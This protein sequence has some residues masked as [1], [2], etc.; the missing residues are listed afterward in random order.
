[1]ENLHKIGGSNQRLFAAR[2][3]LWYGKVDETILLFSDCNLKQAEN[4][5]RIQVE[6]R[7]M[8]EGIVNSREWAEIAARKK[9]IAERA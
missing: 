5:V 4:F 6:R 3:L 2:S 8:R 1:M 9:A 7:G